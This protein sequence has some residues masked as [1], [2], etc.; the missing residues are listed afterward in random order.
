M[1]HCEKI[2]A[3]NVTKLTIK[4]RKRLEEKSKKRNFQ[5]MKHE[6]E[7]KEKMHHIFEQIKEC[8]ILVA[9]NGDYFF[10]IVPSQDTEIGSKIIEPFDENHMKKIKEELED[11]GFFV[12]EIVDNTTRYQISWPFSNSENFSK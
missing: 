12:D 8:I 4:N 1:I 5:M 10:T 11:S 3:T 2:D 6:E 9:E 7:S